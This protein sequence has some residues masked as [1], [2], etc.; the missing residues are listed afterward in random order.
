[1]KPSGTRAI[2]VASPGERLT[3]RARIWRSSRSET[4]SLLLLHATSFCGAVFEPLLGAVDDLV[5]LAVAPD[6]RG[7]GRSDAPADPVGLS[8][9]ALAADAVAWIDAIEAPGGLV[10]A[11]HSCGA[12]CALAAAA[13]RPG[14]VLGVFAIEP[15]LFDP[16]V[17]ADA[18]SYPGSRFMAAQ[19]RK[20]RPWFGSPEEARERLAA[21]P[22]FSGF[23]R[24]ALDAFLD[25][26]LGSDDGGG[27]RLLCDPE[28][29][30]ACYEGAGALDPWP[31]LASILAPVRLLLGDRGFVAPAFRDRLITEIPG[32]R[33]ETVAGG[34]HF[35]ALERPLE[36][37]AA[38]ARFVREVTPIR[39]A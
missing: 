34:T 11:G 17:S 25:G 24:A 16:P 35:V 26:G 14:R 30:A 19:A 8:W 2:E 32:T 13:A 18:D 9:T 28:R 3:L 36:V 12:T 38:L 33:I 37:G 22:P 27:V 23:D 4:P 7:H 1:M 10:L 5:T 20:R 31:G 21:R 15:V 29:E 39:V 6:A